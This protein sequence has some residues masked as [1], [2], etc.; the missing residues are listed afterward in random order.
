MTHRKTAG[1]ASAAYRICCTT[2]VLSIAAVV[3][4]WPGAGQAQPATGTPIPV[5]MSAPLTTQFASDGRFMREGAELAIK[6]I[7]AAGGIKGRPIQLFVE[8]DQGPNPTAAANA[9]IKMITQDHVVAILGPHY[10]PGV[11][12]DLPLLERYQVP[13]LTG[14]VGPAITAQGN[15]FIFRLRVNDNLG[16]GLLVHYVTHELNW[17]KIGIDYVNTAF[18]QGG[19]GAL[20]AELTR[21]N[22]AP[23]LVQT[24][25]DATKDFSPQLLAFDQAGV[26]GVILWTDDVPMGLLTKQIRTLGLK[27]GIAGNAAQAQRNVIALSGDASEGN[28][29]FGEFVPTNSDPVV[30]AWVARYHGVYGAEPEIYASVYYDGAK[31]LA[32]AM[33]QAT[34]MTGPA[35]RDALT[36]TKDFR[37]VITT[38]TA[39][40][41]G[42]M[43]HS[44]LITRNESLHPVIVKRV[45]D[46]P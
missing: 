10:T 20:T 22:I 9:D 8:D 30:Q 12:A 11:L 34:E 19:L 44:G 7:N 17:K 6:E 14:A 37:G 15:K 40:P 32:N 29:A 33:M 25:L 27:F 3:A 24:H 13:G 38:Y 4:A 31:V 46:Q 45:S 43:V 28:Y 41:T 26:D 21:E 36:K 5:G 42:D 2:A 16:A 39:S 23:A 1:T 18:G 35:I